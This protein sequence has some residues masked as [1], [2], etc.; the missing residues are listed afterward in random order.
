MHALFDVHASFNVHGSSK[1]HAHPG[2]VHFVAQETGDGQTTVRKV[3][4]AHASWMFGWQ[5]A[6]PVQGPLSVLAH[7]INLA[8]LSAVPLKH[9]PVHQ[10]WHVVA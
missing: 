5:T 3:H 4:N 7:Y 9:P 8:A 6:D 1:V 10:E 2:Q